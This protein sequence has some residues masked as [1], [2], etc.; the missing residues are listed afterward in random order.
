M[1]KFAV[2][3]TVLKHSRPMSYDVCIGR[4]S[5]LPKGA[6]KVFFEGIRLICS[7]AHFSSGP[8]AGNSFYV[9]NNINKHI[10]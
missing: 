8:M 4:A 6:K 5:L 9:S 7:V 10:F 2:K 3:Y 1:D